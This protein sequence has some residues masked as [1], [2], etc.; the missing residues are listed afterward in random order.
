MK[1]AVSAI[2][3]YVLNFPPEKI[4]QQIR[5]AVKE[6]IPDAEET[7]SYAISTFKLNGINLV[8]FALFKRHIGFYAI[9]TGHERFKHEL[10]KYKQGKGSV[11]F[12][13]NKPMPLKLIAKFATNVMVKCSW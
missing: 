13:W 2:D 8:H 1:K 11:Q 3:E 10:L 4:L 6:A 5:T 12:P 9:P 7:I